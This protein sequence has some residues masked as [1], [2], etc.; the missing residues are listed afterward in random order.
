MSTPI[1]IKDIF[2]TDAANVPFIKIVLW[3]PSLAG[4][5]SLLTVYNV[6]RKVEDPDTIY[7]ALKKIDDPSGRT[8]FYDQSTFE[9]PRGQG[10]SLPMLRYQLWSV[11]G[12]KRHHVQR[13]VVL[14]GADGIVI[15]FDP[16]TDQWPHNVESLDEL[17]SLRNKELNSG[18]IPYLIVLNKMDL[19]AEKRSPTDD[20]M[21]L[22]VDK[23][24]ADNV[25]NAYMRVI[26]T[27][28]LEAR[29]DLMTKLRDADRHLYLD[30]N[31]RLKRGE[32]PNS[33]RKIAQPI[34]QLTREIVVKRI[35]TARSVA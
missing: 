1:T 35:K 23:S 6:L 25:G 16:T 10:T 34:E 8:I 30:E 2:K 9:L 15:M 14:E 27:S 26:E 11:A 19:P 22:L 12:Q 18:E 32:R 28:C 17:I 24:L 7:S 31:G 13:K 33:V 3:G 21:Q 29:N 5:T 4:K 20:F